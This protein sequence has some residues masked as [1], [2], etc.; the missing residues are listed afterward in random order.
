MVPLQPISLKVSPE[1]RARIKSNAATLGYSANKFMVESLEA[2]MSQI[3]EDDSSPPGI[4]V[5]VRTARDL[6][7][8]TPA[9]KRESHRLR[10]RPMHTA[11]R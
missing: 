10:K 8:R 9:K 2:I 4:V 5:L 6:R 11:S 3:E 7:E 1:T